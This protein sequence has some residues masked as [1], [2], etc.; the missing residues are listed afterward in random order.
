MTWTSLHE[1]TGIAVDVIV[2]LG[3][4]ATAVKL[5]LFNVLGRRWRSEVTCTHWE[6]PDSSVVF[7]ADY[8]VTN[9]GERPLD[10]SGVTMVLTGARNTGPLL[11]PDPQR[12]YAE[13]SLSPSPDDRS[14]TRLCSIQPG[15]RS[16]F[17]LRAH[18]PRLDEIVFVEAR[19]TREGGLAEGSYRSMYVKAGANRAAATRAPAQ[20]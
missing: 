8:Q 14:M 18:L 6:L 5:R 19:F 13:R 1:I 2:V 11:E 17:T 4:L 16:I 12:R 9:T 15:E 7:A 3:A 20:E 10:I